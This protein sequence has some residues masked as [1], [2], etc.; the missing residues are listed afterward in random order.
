MKPHAIQ[1]SQEWI[2]PYIRV[3]K[4]TGGDLYRHLRCQKSVTNAMEALLGVENCP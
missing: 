3:D 4:R 2:Y 1:V